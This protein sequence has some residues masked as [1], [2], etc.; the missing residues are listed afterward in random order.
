M[1][2]DTEI[3]RVEPIRQN[4][5]AVKSFSIFIDGEE[6][7]IEDRTETPN[8]LLALAGLASAEYYLIEVKNKRQE[9]FQ[10]RGDETIHIQKGD[11]FVSVFTGPTT[12]SDLPQQFGVENFKSGLAA[13]GYTAAEVGDGNLAFKY[14]VEVGRLKGQVV[15]LGF[16]VPPDFPVTPPSGPHVKPHIHSMQGGGVHPTGGVHPSSGY[17]GLPDDFQYW[18]RPFPG[19]NETR[20]TVADYLA[21]VR[22]LWATQ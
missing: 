8:Q 18:S 7:V 12:V 4:E 19:W 3:N 13:L 6:F 9:S 5:A 1:G 20:K 11:T 16:N 14:V 10:G 22:H 15:T 21:F 17:S 2:T